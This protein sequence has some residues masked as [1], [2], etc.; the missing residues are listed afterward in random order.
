MFF[1]MVE[2]S[3]NGSFFSSFFSTLTFLIFR[4]AWVG[5]LGGTILKGFCG[6]YCSW[7][8]SRSIP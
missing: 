6:S 5:I 3:D 8:F 2:L 1:K 4:G 7:S